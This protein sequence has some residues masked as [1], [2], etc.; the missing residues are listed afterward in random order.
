M[1]NTQLLT[2]F[3][4]H[5]TRPHFPKVKILC[6]HISEPHR[7]RLSVPSASYGRFPVTVVILWTMVP[8]RGRLPQDGDLSSFRGT[9]G[10][11]KT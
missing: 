6:R 2:T 7:R 11:D 1:L 3:K 10:V 9:Y 8:Y 5:Q 4:D